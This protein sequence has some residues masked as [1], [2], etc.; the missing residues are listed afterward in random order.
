M[1]IHGVDAI[2]HASLSNM[3]YLYEQIKK[4]DRIINY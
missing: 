3:K 4:A 2:D 1:G